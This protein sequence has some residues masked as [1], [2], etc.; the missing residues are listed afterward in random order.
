[1]CDS[2]IAL[3]VHGGFGED[4]FQSIAVGLEVVGHGGDLAVIRE[5][6]R[7]AEADGLEYF[8]DLALGEGVAVRELLTHGLRTVAAAGQCARPAEQFVLALAPA[9]FPR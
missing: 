9:V 3:A 2:S 1:M 7:R 6:S 5:A 4:L 8:L